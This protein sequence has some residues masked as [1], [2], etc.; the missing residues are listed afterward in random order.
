MYYLNFDL[1]T[2]IDQYWQKKPLLIRNAFENFEDIITPDEL[3]GLACEEAVSSR[4]VV[5]KENDWQ[6]IEGPFEDYTQ[7]GDKNWQ[8]LVQ[9]LNHWHPDSADFINAF[10]FL[11]DWRFDDLM[12]SFATPGGGV[13]AHIDNYDVFII[14]GEGERHWTVGD[15][16]QY[17]PKNNDPTT[18]L[19][20]GFEPIIDAILQKGDLLYI[21]PGYPHQGQTITTAM[22]YSMGFRAPSQQELFSE[23][24]DNLID[25]AIGLK[26]FTSNSEPTQ[27]SQ[28]SAD[29]QQGMMA[30]ISEFASSPTHYQAVLGKMLSLNRFELDI[31]EPQEVYRAEELD[32]YINQGALL[33]R[34]GGLKLLQLESDSVS[35]VFINGEAFEYPEAI[36]KNVTQL[37]EKLSFDNEQATLLLQCSATKALILTLLNRG[38]FYFGE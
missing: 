2:F 27:P 6:M 34:I 14:Q 35:R 3:A 13:G 38:Y 37:A 19:I 22:S 12:V 23:I 33:Y 31:C 4:V 20:E 32:D 18:P 28:V 9:A 1:K 25:N 21:P 29:H 8:L 17:A 36:A 30:L 26:R 15:K 10:R 16:G 24:A 11:P 5:T 7:F